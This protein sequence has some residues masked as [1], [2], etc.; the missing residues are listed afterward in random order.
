LKPHQID[1]TGHTTGA[2]AL[3]VIDGVVTGLVE[4][5]G[6]GGGGASAPF[7]QRYWYRDA[8]DV[9]S[10]TVPVSPTLVSGM[11]ITIPSS[12]VGRM[13]FVDATLGWT[14]SHTNRVELYLDGTAITPQITGNVAGSNSMYD[15]VFSR[16]P[17][18]L[19]SGVSHTVEVRWNASESTAAVTLTERSLVVDVFESTT[20]PINIGGSGGSSS[21]E[22]WQDY[23]PTLTSTGVS[24]TLGTGSVQAGRYTANGSTVKGWARITFGTSGVNAGTGTYLVSLPLPQRTASAG[25]P[26]NHRALGA[27]FLTD[28]S[29][30]IHYAGTTF[31]PS[32]NSVSV[33]ML[34]TGAANGLV[35]SAVP[36]AW[37]ASDNIW[38]QFEY[39]AETSV[40]GGGSAA[41][42]VRDR[43][44][45]VPSG[46]TS[47]DEF[48]DGV[49]D[50][51]W[52]RVDGGGAPAANVTWTES[53]DVLS[54]QH[55]GGDTA[56]NIHGIVRSGVGTMV[57]GDAF[58][59]C[60]TLLGPPAAMYSMGGIILSD[61]ITH[62]SGNQ[63]LLL[64]HITSSGEQRTDARPFTGWNAQGTPP[65]PLV[66]PP[67]A[68]IFARLVFLGASTW[69]AD[70]SPDGVSWIKGLT[71]V[72]TIAPTHVGLLASSW[73]TGNKHV[74][75]YEFLRRTS[76]VT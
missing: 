69:R 23:T 49:L 1:A 53:A 6:G 2:Y 4:D 73:G 9:N 51:A 76:G 37:A 29:A 16:I 68:R 65:A 26:P 3:D 27:I 14:G 46:T 19:T 36:F 11:T 34:A 20:S 39:E 61:G 74:A 57:N 38:V 5:T 12:T 41:S 25:N 30:G 75:S 31:T 42:P 10:G 62:G 18:T 24:P 71:V 67:G 43:R 33:G 28:A 63:A 22:V 13:G 59:T 48:N 54:L 45:S 60:V 50:P 17:I 47:I 55:E 70:V 32:S 66:T 58:I 64:T 44:W 56:N 40:G 35:T 72:K 15:A 8:A 7:G 52:V 21:G